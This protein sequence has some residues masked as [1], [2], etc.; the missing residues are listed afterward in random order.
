MLSLSVKSTRLSL[1]LVVCIALGSIAT[2]N[3][4]QSSPPGQ[5]TNQM[6]TQAEKAKAPTRT[7]DSTT[8]SGKSKKAAIADKA[9]SAGYQSG[10][11]VIAAELKGIAVSPVF[12]LSSGSVVLNSSMT[13][14]SP[15][16]DA[17][18]YYTIDGSQ[19]TE[20]SIQFNADNPIVID[21]PMTIQ[22]ITAATGY[23]TSPVSS[24]RYSIGTKAEASLSP[25]VSPVFSV[26]QG[27]VGFGTTVSITTPTPDAVIYFTTDGKTPTLSSDQF[28]SSNPLTVKAHAIIHAIAIAK[29]HATSA[30]SSVEY[31]IAPYVERHTCYQEKSGYDF[32]PWLP[33]MSRLCTNAA[34]QNYFDVAGTATVANNVQYLYNAQQSTNQVNADLFTATFWPGF[35]AVLAGTATQ[36]S[37]Q[38]AADTP[39]PGSATPA[40]P[41][42]TESASAA[43][44][45]LEQGGDFNLR[46]PVPIMFYANTHSTGSINFLPNV[47]FSVNG[48]TDQN[49]ITQSTEYNWNVPFEGYFQTGSVETG[50]DGKS[51]AVIYLDFKGGAE[52]V[53]K[54][55][56]S[57]VGLTSGRYFFLGQAA[58]GIEFMN[59]VRVGLQ[60]FIG[61]SQIYS[62]PSTTAGGAPVQVK[63]GLGGL[64]LVVSFSPTAKKAS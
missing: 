11:E 51:S 26:A 21:K 2:T 43:V 38:P 3:Y 5:A 57:A 53:S 35:Q 22:A 46:F 37:S 19:P 45:R 24:V 34:I 31:S 30:V 36:G 40:T 8:T 47:G 62:V 41:V 29:D 33:L 4:A 13:L 50:A 32:K 14:S 49:T 64:H 63:S 25:V 61:P 23:S 52:G 48:L 42:I 1:Q 54:D 9:N 7:K 59:S 20:S 17:I 39:T 10:V 60:Y 18:I 28:D 58:A 15:T 56:A 16:P 27:P 55:F 44:A 6:K 12:S